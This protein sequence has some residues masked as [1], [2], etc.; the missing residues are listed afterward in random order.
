MDRLN[1]IATHHGG[2]VPLH[3]RLFAQWLHHAYP[4][5][6]PYPHVSGTT[7]PMLSDQYVAVTGI[8]AEA[9]H[10]EIWEIINKTSKLPEVHVE[11]LPWNT[12]EELFV[13]HHNPK[14]GAGWAVKQSV[15]IIASSATLVLF[16]AKL[17]RANGSIQ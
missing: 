9:T 17:L 16:F 2:Y 10:E 13:R 15:M 1:D 6:C 4:R 11:E 3:G 8:E 7:N 12:E 14:R 5:E